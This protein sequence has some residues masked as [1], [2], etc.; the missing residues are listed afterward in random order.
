VKTAVTLS[1]QKPIPNLPICSIQ[2][3]HKGSSHFA[4]SLHPEE[5]IWQG[6]SKFC[7]ARTYGAFAADLAPCGNVVSSLIFFFF[8]ISLE[9]CAARKNM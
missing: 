3:Q 9:K 8:L 6:L 2:L 4:S 1:W 5:T 7:V